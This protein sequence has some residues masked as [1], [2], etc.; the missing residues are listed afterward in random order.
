MKIP[1]PNNLPTLLLGSCLAI[2]PTLANNSIDS[3]VT[4]PPYELG[5]MGKKWD[6]SGIAFNTQVWVECLRVLK[7]GSHLL[8]FGGTRTHHRMACAIE[9]AGF[10]IRDELDWIYGTG[11]PKSHNISIGIDKQTGGMKHRGKRTTNGYTLNSDPHNKGVNNAKAMPQHQ[12]ITEEAKQWQG[13][14]TALKPAREP[15]TLA[16]KP[17]EGT[18]AANVLEYGTGGLNIDATRIGYRWTANVL[19]DELAAA[20][21][22]EPA[23]FFYVAKASTAEKSA[24]LSGEGQLVSESSGGMHGAS[25]E[26][27][28]HNKTFEMK[29]MD[30][31]TPTAA[32]SYADKGFL[33]P[34]L[35]HHPTVKPIQLM[36]YLCRLITPPNGIVLDPFCGSGSTGCAAV[37]E[38]FRFVGIDLNQE[39]LDIAKARIDYWSYPGLGCLGR[40]RE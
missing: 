30:G 11:F 28:I 31:S 40:Q 10:E 38:G 12:G 36:R 7:P 25:W 13:W 14:G 26:R 18:V 16:R 2:L 23:R 20:E 8:A 15:I 17:L 22:G 32:G 9:D 29:P 19:F 35:N 37:L 1:F 21:L 6:S 39:Y 27:V 3:I 33:T 24:G 5:F 34:K 4:D